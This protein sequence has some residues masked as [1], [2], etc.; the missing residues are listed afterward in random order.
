[1]SSIS[2]FVADVGPSIFL[3]FLSTSKLSEGR[4][5]IH[6]FDVPTNVLSMYLCVFV[7]SILLSINCLDIFLV[8]SNIA[9]FMSVTQ[10][11]SKKLY[12]CHDPN[13]VATGTHT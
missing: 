7:V 8:H 10:Y 1:M 6:Y 4:F 12:Y 5:S 9:L 3:S 11:K 2:I 13:R